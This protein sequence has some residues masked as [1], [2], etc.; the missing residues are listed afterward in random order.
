VGETALT[1]VAITYDPQGTV[2]IFVNGKRTPPTAAPFRTVGNASG[3]LR[4]GGS[5]RE[6]GEGFRG[7]IDE[8][9]I[10][11]GIVYPKDFTRP[12][13]ALDAD[14]VAT[15]AL[16][17]FDEGDGLVTADFG[18]AKLTATMPETT[19]NQP[20]WVQIACVSDLPPP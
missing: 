6:A 8:I 12:V 19:G 5:S 13:K 17:H 15:I 9:R 11:R 14:P 2:S 20:K 10:L 1:H 3:D 18:P 16:W 4:I 7:L